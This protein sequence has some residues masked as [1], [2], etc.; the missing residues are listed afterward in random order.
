MKSRFFAPLFAALC[1]AL[2]INEPAPEGGSL[3][4]E[5]EASN[6]DATELAAEQGED[7]ATTGIHAT[8]SDDEA[9]IS[10]EPGVDTTEQSADGVTEGE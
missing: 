1:F 4:P 7:D 6:D 5:M 10:A 9:P 3:N 2:E 8:E